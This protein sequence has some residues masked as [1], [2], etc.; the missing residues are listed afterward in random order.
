[1]Q[2][3]ENNLVSLKYIYLIHELFSNCI[4]SSDRKKVLFKTQMITFLPQSTQ[5]F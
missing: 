2:C 5:V 3:L 4:N 1:M